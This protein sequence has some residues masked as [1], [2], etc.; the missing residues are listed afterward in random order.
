[1]TC[2][3]TGLIGGIDE[4]GRAPLA[5][6]VVSACVIWENLPSRREKVKDSKLLTEKQRE[7][8]FDW[9]MDHACKVSVGLATH[10][11]IEA[12]NIHHASLLSMERAIKETYIEADLLLVDGLFSI[13]GYKTSKA[14][15]KGD[16]KC[17]F[18][19]CASIIAKVTR[20]RLM[21]DYDQQ[22][23]SYGWKKNKGYPTADHRK[24][25]A[26]F[27]ISPIHRKTFRG[28]REYVS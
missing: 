8:F 19:A 25:I 24:A 5:G 2:R 22:Y 21:A 17:F 18:V 4:A 3:L 11:E 9:I 6:P 7:Y 16:R 1:M 20:D 26:Q 28:V 12:L 10:E 23:P 13:K 15:V 14:V 27:G